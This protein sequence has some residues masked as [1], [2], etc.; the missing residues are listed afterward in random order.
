MAGGTISPP[1]DSES[2]L[3]SMSEKQR[4]QQNLPTKEKAKTP[5]TVHVSLDNADTVIEGGPAKFF[6]CWFPLDGLCP[7][8]AAL[9]A[10]WVGKHDRSRVLKPTPSGNWFPRRAAVHCDS[11]STAPATPV[12]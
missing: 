2:E 9:F 8:Q 12:A 7:I 3:W 1:Q 4:Q 11:I 10:A 6:H 5:S